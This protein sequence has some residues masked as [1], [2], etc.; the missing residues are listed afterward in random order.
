[1]V[2]GDFTVDGGAAAMAR[3]LESQPDVD[4]VFVASDLMAL[5]AIRTLREHGRRVPEDV[6]VVGFDDVREAQ[7]TTPALSTMRQPL[8]ELGRTMTRVLLARIGGGDAAQ[9]TVLPTELVRR[10][11]A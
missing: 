6:A 7:F 1:M 10:Q 5:G 3:L 4:G 8:D 9:R 2:E 11:T